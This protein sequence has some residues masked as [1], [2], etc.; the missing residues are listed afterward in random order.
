MFK[1]LK[2]LFSK[3]Y[4]DLNGAAFK[5]RF[6]ACKNAMLIDVRTPGEFNAGTIKGAKNINVTGADFYREL[7][8]LS[9][10]KE[11]FLFC[12]SGAR[13]GHACRIMSSKGFKAVNLSGGIGTWPK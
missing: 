3:N 9:K 7:E 8:K 2:S 11:Y 10:D 6:Q 1:F 5:S 4:E 12:R 13:S